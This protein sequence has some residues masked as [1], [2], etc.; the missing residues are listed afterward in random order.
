MYSLDLS[1]GKQCPKNWALDTCTFKHQ[2]RSAPT[3]IARRDWDRFFSQIERKYEKSGSIVN[4][5]KAT[6]TQCNVG[7]KTQNVDTPRLTW[8]IWIMSTSRLIPIDKGFNFKF[9]YVNLDFLRKSPFFK[10]V[11]LTQ[12][13]GL[14][15]FLFYYQI[16]WWFKILNTSFHLWHYLVCD[17][18]YLYQRGNTRFWWW[19]YA[20]FSINRSIILNG[21]IYE[22]SNPILC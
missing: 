9:F 3:S 2:Q 11:L 20:I 12:N 19:E 22:I 18:L 21:K 5:F 14:V 7:A 16:G 17:G 8:I 13:V 6:V 1:I 4:I 10:S 15:L